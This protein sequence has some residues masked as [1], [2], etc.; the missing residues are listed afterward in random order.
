MLQVVTFIVSLIYTGDYRII[1][2][3]CLSMLQVTI[4][5]L[6]LDVYCFADLHSFCAAG[7]YRIVD[8]RRLLFR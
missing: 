4:I 2:H 5:L 3:G 6:I 8:L 1:H 7:D